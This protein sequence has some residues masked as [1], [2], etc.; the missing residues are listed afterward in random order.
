VGFAVS[1]HVR[2]AAHRNRARRRIREAYRQVRARIPADVELIVVARPTAATC[3]FTELLEDM[4]GLAAAL[5]RGARGGT[6]R[7]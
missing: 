7:T 6:T 3:P 1:R 4:V 2:G 5:T